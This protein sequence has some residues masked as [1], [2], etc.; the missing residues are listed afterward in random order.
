MQNL[1]TSRRPENQ[2][3]TLANETVVTSRQDVARWSSK[4]CAAS[5][6]RCVVWMFKDSAQFSPL[7]VLD[8]ALFTDLE[9]RLFI[10]SSLEWRAYFIGLNVI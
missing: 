1:L 3:F 4:T 9:L 8:T 2:C 6:P 10:C 5:K 7:V